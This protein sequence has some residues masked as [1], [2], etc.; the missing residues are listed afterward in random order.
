MLVHTLEALPDSP[1]LAVSSAAVRAWLAEHRTCAE[2]P[3][4]RYSAWAAE[5]GRFT[6]TPPEQ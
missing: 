2:A 4:D 5:V 1:D 6:F 3:A